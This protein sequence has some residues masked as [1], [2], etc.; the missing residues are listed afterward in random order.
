MARRINE[1]LQ[2]TNPRG[3]CFVY[4]RVGSGKSTLMVTLGTC[5]DPEVRR[6]WHLWREGIVKNETDIDNYLRQPL[7]NIPAPEGGEQ[8]ARP[9]EIERELDLARNM[10]GHLKPRERTRL[11]AVLYQP[12]EQTWDDAYSIIVGAD[13]WMTL[14]QAV[15]AVD[16]SFPKVGPS[17]DVRGRRV[18]R[19]KKIPDQ[20][21]LVT[22]LRYATH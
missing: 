18:S 10:F 9:V 22:A 1:I 2:G 8:N 19:W 4:A 20:E 14:W 21:T 13:G 7:E 3:E 5:D 16:P 6:F 11:R 12:T 17:T 15:L